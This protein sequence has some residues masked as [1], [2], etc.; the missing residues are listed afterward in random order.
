MC[1]LKSDRMESI[2][3]PPISRNYKITNNLNLLV[4]VFLS[5]P[6]PAPPHSFFQLMTILTV[7]ANSF[8]LN[9]SYS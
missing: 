2:N 5:H 6:W 9:A 7:V 1:I 3:P 4:S 8:I